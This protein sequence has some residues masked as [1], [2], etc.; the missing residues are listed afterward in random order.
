MVFGPSVGLGRAALGARSP[1][2]A[3]SEQAS[4]RRV[5]VRSPGQAPPGA[6]AQVGRVGRASPSPPGPPPALAREGAGGPGAGAG[7]SVRS[8]ERRPAGHGGRARR[9]R[10]EGRRSRQGREEARAGADVG[11][12]R[13][14]AGPRRR[15]FPSP[16]AAR[17]AGWGSAGPR[18]AAVCDAVVAV[19]PRACD[20]RASQEGAVMSPQARRPWARKG[21]EDPRENKEVQRNVTARLAAG[22]RGRWF[23]IGVLQF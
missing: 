20:V 3:G 22:L 4:R 18:P 21:R 11:P 14:A 2:A 17:D 13:P 15:C 23:G 16:G 9:R 5:G 1:S 6:G 10:R 7:A 8:A 19:G 12:G